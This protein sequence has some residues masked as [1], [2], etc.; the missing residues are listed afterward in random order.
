MGGCREKRAGVRF[1][2]H[3][4]CWGNGCDEKVG[5]MG[6]MNSS[7]VVVCIVVKGSRHPHK[8]STC[9]NAGNNNMMSFRTRSIHLAPP[10]WKL[11]EIIPACSHWLSTMMSSNIVK[12]VPVAYAR[13]TICSSRSFPHVVVDIQ[14]FP[15]LSNRIVQCAQLVFLTLLKHQTFSNVIGP[16]A[17]SRSVSPQSQWVA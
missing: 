9:W 16:S 11:H 3:E 8:E 17:G 14:V 5:S 15:T 1:V 10:C 4:F 6:G 13:I 2:G 7:Q 12:F